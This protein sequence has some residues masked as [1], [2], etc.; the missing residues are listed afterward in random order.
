MKKKNILIL[1]DDENAGSHLTEIILSLGCNCICVNNNKLNLN[2]LLKTTNFDLAFV[3]IPTIRNSPFLYSYKNN[4]ININYILFGDENKTISYS[5]LVEYGASD[6]LSEP[7]KSDESFFKLT[8]IFREKKLQEELL[9]VQKCFLGVVENSKDA[10]IVTDKDG[11]V[12]YFNRMAE[13]IFGKNRD[14]VVGA[15]LGIPI[16]TDEY[17]EIDIIRSGGDMGVGEIRASETL[18]RDKEAF[19][20]SI[21]DIT[22]RK[23]IENR[24]AYL[25][26]Y[27]FMTEVFN[28]RGFEETLGR[29]LSRALRFN[30]IGALLWLDLDNF[31]NV[32]DSYGHKVGDELLVRVADNIKKRLR[33]SD[34]IARL[35]G[36]EFAM[37][38]PGVNRAQAEKVAEEIIELVNLS[39][40]IVKDQIVRTSPSIGIVIF[41]DHGKNFEDLLACA[42]TVM[43]Q[44]KKK[45]RNC[46]VFYEPQGDHRAQSREQ[47]ALTE[48]IRESL[49]KNY[50]QI[51]VQP[52]VQ[53]YGEEVSFEVLLRLKYNNKNVDPG[54]FFPHSERVG[55]IRNIDRWVIENVLPIISSIHKKTPQIRFHI[56]ISGKS[57]SDDRFLNY[58]EKSLLVSGVNPASLIFE[59]TETA[60][61]SNIPMAQ[62]FIERLNKLGCFFALDDFGVGFSSFF[63]LKSLPVQILKID[64]GFIRNLRKSKQDQCIVQAI[65]HVA[66]GFGKKIVA[67][68]VEDQ[69][70]LCLLK[71]YGVDYLQGYFL[72]H[73]VPF[74]TL[75]RERVS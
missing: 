53:S 58:L 23:N 41:P 22:E 33:R 38:L 5:K 60:A 54:I 30:D 14:D 4:F 19:L 39:H 35:G 12:Q 26:S 67:E 11:I 17:K 20:I 56:N 31:K 24:L 44:A 55:L 48:I 50:F 75:I 72:G 16:I 71:T 65:C 40:V 27:D 61:I 34:I 47:I 62:K 10:I 70:T 3:N 42:D 37:F 63:H 1:C 7:I 15:L 21:R 74:R 18:W 43:Y 46:F 28:R 45:G 36:D 52:I 25:A 73:P 57:V 8:R 68:W 49:E 2:S 13:K 32:N 29:E 6:L 9:S 51:N 64:G 59:I 66:K 69:E